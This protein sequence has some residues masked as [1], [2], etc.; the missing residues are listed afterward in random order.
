MFFIMSLIKE[1][2][3]LTDK[4]IREYGE[5]TLLLMQVG[6]FFEVYGVKTQNTI[7]NSK[8]YDFCQI[9]ELNITEKNVC[10]SSDKENIMMAGFKDMM[11]EKYLKKLQSA[12]FT[13]VVYTQDQPAKNTTRSCAGIFSPGTYF[14]NDNS[15]LTNNISCIWLDL[16]DNKVLFKGKY[17]IMGIANIDILTGKT[18]MMQF[19]QPYFNNPTTFDDLERFISIYQ[20]SETILI[21]NI[22]SDIINTIISYI[23]LNSQK[24]HKISLTGKEVQTIKAKNCENQI[25]QKEMI[26]RFYDISFNIFQ[27]DFSRHIIACQSFCFLLDFVECHNPQLVRKI[28]YPE[29]EKNSN[30]LYLANHSLKQLNIIDDHNYKGKFA[31]VSSMLNECCT[32]MGKRKFQNMITTPTRD[33]VYLQEE[34]D[35]TDYLLKND[36]SN[37]E[38]MKANLLMIKDLSK[39]ERSIFLKKISPKSFIIL[40]ENLKIIRNIYI[41]IQ[42]KK[43]LVPFFSKNKIFPQLKDF[44]NN[45]QVFI[46]KHFEIEIAQNSDQINGFDNNFIRKGINTELDIKS[47]ELKRNELYLEE[48]RK[49]LNGLVPEK[50][51]AKTCDFIKIHETEKNC[52]S[53]ICTSRRCKLLET[54]LPDKETETILTIKNIVPEMIIPFKIGKKL[55]EYKTQSSSNNFI[56]NSHIKSICSKITTLKI[57]L[58]DDISFVYHNILTKF[59]SYQNEFQELIDFITR[60]DIIYTKAIIADKYNLSKPVINQQ[61]KSFFSVKKIRHL[62][63]ENIQSGELYISNDLNLGINTQDGILLYG[64]NAVGKTSFIKSIGITIILAQAGFFVPCEEFTYSPYEYIFTRI[65][66]NDNLFK[67]MSTFAVEMSELRTILNRSNENSLILGDELCSGTE[68]SSAIGIFVSGIQTI[69]QKKCSF[70]FA[71]HLHEIVDYDEI[72]E[73]KSVS[74]K[75]MEVY[76]DREKDLLVYNRKLLDGPGNNMYGLEVCKSLHLPDQ[77]LENAFNIR[78]KYTGDSSVLSFKPS[79]F[80]SK[81]LVGICEKCG[82]KKATETHH[83]Q[84][85]KNADKNGIIKHDDMVFHKNNIAN[86]MALCEDCH[87]SIHKLKQ[88]KRVK[89]TKKTT[90]QSIS[91]I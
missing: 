45:I 38:K 85:Q 71:T 26:Q 13:A 9:C 18:Y 54:N 67:G 23:N 36:S 19:E 28:S 50:T 43:N 29:L 14:S 49:C 6:S 20:P 4:Y 32:S 69:V 60:I 34:Y 16:I 84:F 46:E 12:G 44:L 47:D 25:Y 39:L 91:T 72:K 21:S 75:H 87:H 55:F 68:I 15:R 40:L 74:L 31:S 62:L 90:I 22:D 33:I 41:E 10:V 64:T 37:F 65:L 53:L 89:T 17:L 81:K 52:F 70:L 7:L 5:K 82:E 61:E 51:K 77:F 78:L 11:I 66:G 42:E 80:N 27:H 30:Q 88:T 56:T 73:L 76:Y 63:I 35:I 24:I 1:Y 2:F 3:E 83:L 59:E 8:I 79:H 58:K 57:G 48:I 86:L